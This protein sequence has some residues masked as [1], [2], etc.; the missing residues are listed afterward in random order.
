MILFLIYADADIQKEW[1]KVKIK[2]KPL[3]LH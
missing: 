3:K 2:Q 1:I